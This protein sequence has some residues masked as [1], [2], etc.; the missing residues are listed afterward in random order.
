MAEATRSVVCYNSKELLS[1]T[2]GSAILAALKKAA[3]SQRAHRLMLW[4]GLK[5]V[6]SKKGAES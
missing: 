3:N 2:D 6:E 1:A 4:A 5:R